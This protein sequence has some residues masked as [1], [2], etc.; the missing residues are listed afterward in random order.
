[1]SNDEK[2]ELVIEGFSLVD[3]L[4]EAVAWH[5]QCCSGER[6]AEACLLTLVGEL[7][8]DAYTHRRRLPTKEEVLQLITP[9]VEHY[10]AEEQQQ[11]F[12]K[13]APPLGVADSN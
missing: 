12:L 10:T 9:W 8:V 4:D 13:H 5:R 11:D 7:Y 3:A 6:R 2:T 1:M